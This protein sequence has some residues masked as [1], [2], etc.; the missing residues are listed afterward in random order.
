MRRFLVE[1]SVENKMLKLQKKKTKVV[2]ASL[3][4]GESGQKSS[5]AEDFAA[6]FEED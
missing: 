4:Q 5:T 6:I 1:N 3:G 2:D